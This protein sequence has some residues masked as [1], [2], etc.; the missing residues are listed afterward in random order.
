MN[1]TRVAVVGAG[2]NGLAA[3]VT[4]ARAGLAVDV[5]NPHLACVDATLTAADLAALDVAAPVRFDEAQFPEGVNVEVLTAPA[6]GA[7][8]MRV[9]ERGVGE[10]RS[11]G[12]G[13]VAA[14]VAALAH[15]GAQTGALT[16]RIPGGEVVVTITRGGYAKR[17][18]VDEYRAQKRGGKG[19]R[20]AS[21]R[22][23]D[24]VRNFFTTTSHHWLLFFTNLG[25]VYRVKAYEL[26]E[27]A[28]DGKGQHVANLLAFQPDEQIAAVYAIEDYEAAPYLVLATKRGLVKKTRLTEYDSPRSGGL[29]AIKLRED[30]ELAREPSRL[31]A[32]PVETV[33]VP[34]F[35]GSTASFFVEDISLPEM[36][37]ALVDGSAD[38]IIAAARAV[39]ADQPVLVHCT[40]GKDRTG[41][42]IALLLAA[43]G[44]DE[45]A[46]VSDYART[47]T[48]L[49]VI[50][51]DAHLAAT[52]IDDGPVSR[53]DPIG[54]DE[55][56]RSLR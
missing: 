41:V 26:P 21:L 32:L 44:V 34:L 50:E 18:R 37:R 35:L 39:I 36:Y 27:A 54:N 25:R 8:S 38:R 3:A 17:T 23:E 15:E 10:T 16:V 20:G 30:D 55:V 40:V 28:R 42:T 9:H 56:T 13:T 22:G 11:C 6:D 14:T 12:T 43:A 19:V 53:H 49:P 2:P 29:I 24:V 52:L 45:D 4:L 5:G 33:R 48:L 7:V 46:V 31:G 1:L 51:H 47:E